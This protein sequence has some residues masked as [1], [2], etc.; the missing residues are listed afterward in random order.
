MEQNPAFATLMKF[1]EAETQYLS[2]GGGDFSV[3][4]E[5]L[6]PKCVLFQPHSLPYGGEW[7][8]PEGFHSWMKAFGEEWSS[9]E[10]RDPH[11]FP[12]GDDV[13]F[14]RSHVFAVARRTG[15]DID[16]PLLQFFRVKD[17]RILELR[18]FHWDT[19]TMLSGMG[20]TGGEV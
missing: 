19:A 6:H 5:T 1:Y 15:Q 7:H 13:V 4:A 17:D 14:S 2:P 18:P 3:I 11:F 16:W 10:V 12:S 20:Q 8:G 9:L